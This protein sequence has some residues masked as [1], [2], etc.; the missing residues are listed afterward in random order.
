VWCESYWLP[1]ADLVTLGDG[2]TVN[3]G[4]V[5]QTHLFHDRIL[6]MD[7]VTLEPGATL[8]PHGVV[9][10]AA[11]I[12]TSSTVGPASLVLRGEEVPAQTRWRGN[13]IVFWPDDAPRAT[14]PAVRVEEPTSE[15]T[16]EQT[17]GPTGG[18]APAAGA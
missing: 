5:V 11:T 4:C 1:E 18:A 16:S 7:H 12:G 15:P 6:S 8:G 17:A 2:A 10:P 3:R 9:L 14:G 13:P